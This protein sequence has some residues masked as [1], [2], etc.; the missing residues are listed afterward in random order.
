VCATN[1]AVI[2]KNAKK[3]TLT[4]SNFSNAGKSANIRFTVVSP[5]PSAGVK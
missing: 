5:R 3:E 4:N 1:N 2:E